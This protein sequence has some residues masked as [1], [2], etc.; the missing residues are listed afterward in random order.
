M[1]AAVLA[2][3]LVVVGVVVV[4]AV[5]DVVLG[6]VVVVV[7]V[8]VDAD[9]A[10][11]VDVVVEAGGVVVV[12]EGS[13]CAISNCGRGAGSGARSIGSG[14][15]GSSGSSG[16]MPGAMTIELIVRNAAAADVGPHGGRL[17]G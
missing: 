16:P 6:G 15:I 2:V 12:G 8:V 1:D 9:G 10:V 17:P 13:D 11:V 3:V 5:V 7:D 4:A 14:S